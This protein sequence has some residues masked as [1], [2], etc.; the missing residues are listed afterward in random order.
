LIINNNLAKYYH[1]HQ[2][3]QGGAGE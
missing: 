2:T 3:D 1:T